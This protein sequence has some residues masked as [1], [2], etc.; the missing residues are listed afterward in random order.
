LKRLPTKVH[1]TYGWRV[2]IKYSFLK[3][4]LP[5]GQKHA[6]NPRPQ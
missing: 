5:R 6:L 2:A 1:V 4:L 3:L